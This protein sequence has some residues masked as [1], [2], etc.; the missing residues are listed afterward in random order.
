MPR[1][2]LKTLPDPI[3]RADNK[4]LPIPLSKEHLELIGQMKFACKKFKG[5]GLAAPQIGQS[6][7]LAI[8][9]L[10]YYHIPAFAIINPKITWSSKTLE[11]ME[12]GCLS[13]PNKFGDIRRPEKIKVTFHN[14]GGDKMTVELEGL[15]ARVFQHEIDHLNQT[16]ISDKWDKSTVHIL[17][18]EG[19]KK[20]WEL[21]KKE[22]PKK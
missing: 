6:L 1:L 9:N 21:R 13:I 4:D 17:D 2:R 15:A 3:L 19:R 20:L 14:E 8:I 7:N 18:E 5:I 22:I 10:E 11:P 12:E 16:L